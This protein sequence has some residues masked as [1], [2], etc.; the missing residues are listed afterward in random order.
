ML[1]GAMKQISFL[2]YIDLEGMLYKYENG[3]DTEYQIVLVERGLEKAENGSLDYMR[4]HVRKGKENGRMDHC[5][6][7]RDIDE[8][9]GDF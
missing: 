5:V 4:K 8:P 3:G 7:F 9:S 2:L 6:D 1:S